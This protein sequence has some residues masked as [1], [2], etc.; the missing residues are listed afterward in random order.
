MD[1]HKKHRYLKFQI[2]LLKVNRQ[3]V[4]QLLFLFACF[5][6]FIWGTC[7]VVPGKIFSQMTAKYRLQDLQRLIEM[8]L[9]VV[10]R[11]T[12]LWELQ[13]QI[14]KRQCRNLQ[15][16]VGAKKSGEEWLLWRLPSLI[17]PSPPS[18]T[19]CPLPPPFSC[20]VVE[21]VFS[22][23]GLYSFQFD[24]LSRAWLVWINHSKYSPKIFSIFLLLFFFV[25]RIVFTDCYYIPIDLFYWETALTGP[26]SQSSRRNRTRKQRP[27]IALSPVVGC[28]PSIVRDK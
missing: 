23:Y 20:V 4:H 26:Q 14:L 11:D 28:L 16:Y 3:C 5:L 1:V 8:G 17:P 2:N 19:A 24:F 15:S 10:L 27:F 22:N 25:V 6:T 9:V 12:K 7:E 13:C 18:F 21:A